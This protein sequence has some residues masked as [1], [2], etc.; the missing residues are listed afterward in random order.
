MFRWRALE[1]DDSGLGVY[2][3]SSGAVENGTWGV[4]TRRKSAVGEAHIT[5]FMHLGEAINYARDK[6]YRSGPLRPREPGR[7]PGNVYY[8][9]FMPKA[10][11][12]DFGERVI[13][14][15]YRALRGERGG[16]QHGPRDAPAGRLGR[17]GAILVFK[18]EG[19]LPNGKIRW[20]L[21]P[22][23]TTNIEGDID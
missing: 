16:V 11:Y 18:H 22:T 23:L 3:G 9:A 6:A 2:A 13:D 15:R 7:T 12:D 10:Q 21:D 8:V 5:M 19:V 20:K 17:Q 14:V 1:G 4:S